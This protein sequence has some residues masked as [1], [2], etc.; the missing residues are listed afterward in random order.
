MDNEK[1]CYT[2][3]ASMCGLQSGN[4]AFERLKETPNL[5]IAILWFVVFVIKYPMAYITY[6]KNIP[7]C[8]DCKSNKDCKYRVNGI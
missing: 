4:S 6:G 3:T 2:V 1:Y 7:E 5:I 8:E